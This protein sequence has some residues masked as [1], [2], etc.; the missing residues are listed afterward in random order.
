MGPD[1][2]GLIVINQ[3]FYREEIM[4]EKVKAGRI[5]N[6]IDGAW[7]EDPAKASTMRTFFPS[8]ISD[9]KSWGIC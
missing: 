4:S 6:F 9:N 1:K 3:C 2:S 8:R 5:R 7:V